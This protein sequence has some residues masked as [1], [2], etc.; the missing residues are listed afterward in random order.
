MAKNNY[1]DIEPFYILLLL[2][3]KWYFIA[4]LGIV[5]LSIGYFS[6]GKS[7]KQRRFKAVAVIT[8]S[9]RDVNLVSSTADRYLAYT[10]KSILERSYKIITDSKAFLERIVN[11]KYRIKDSDGKTRE[12]ILE[13]YFKSISTEQLIHCVKKIIS[14]KYIKKDDIL[15]VSATTHNPYF[16]AALVNYYIKELNLFYREK[17]NS[18]AKAGVFFVK[19]RVDK[20]EKEL[21]KAETA[22]IAFLENNRGL[23]NTPNTPQDQLFKFKIKKLNDRVRLLSMVYSDLLRKYEGLKFEAEKEIPII[24]VLR[25]AE[26]PFRPVSQNSLK[27]AGVG[28]LAGMIIAAMIIILIDFLKHENGKAVLNALRGR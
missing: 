25:E 7:L 19:K 15:I 12:I 2:L 1:F 21:E 17:M 3:R 28:C 14:L 16:S 4:A 5:G 20:I 27:K 10:R 26:V 9:Y 24:T 23:E 22:V 6:S 11:H 13:D 18:S 8:S